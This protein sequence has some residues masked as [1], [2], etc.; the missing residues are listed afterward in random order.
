MTTTA[1]QTT[2]GVV[3]TTQPSTPTTPCVKINLMIDEPLITNAQFD[4][5]NEPDLSNS[6]DNLRQ[7]NDGKQLIVDKDILAITLTGVN[8]PINGI[9]IKG[10]NIQSINIVTQTPEN[11]SSVPVSNNFSN[12]PTQVNVQVAYDN[13][14]FLDSYDNYLTIM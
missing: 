10:D 4:T 9:T 6:I 7:P 11:P 8:T 14:M 5:P 3:T 2:T 1:S 13:H 12:F